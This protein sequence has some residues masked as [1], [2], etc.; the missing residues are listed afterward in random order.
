MSNLLEY[1]KSISSELQSIKNRV[2]NLVTH[3]PEDWRYKEI[4]LS[5]LIRSFLPKKFSVGTWFVVCP[6]DDYWKVKEKST[7]IDI[8]IYND[9][10]PLLFKKW[11][12]IICVPDA[13][14]AIIEVKSKL[15]NSL[16]QTRH[17]NSKSLYN[18]ILKV[19]KNWQIIIQWK[20]HKND[21]LVLKKLF[22]NGI[23]SFD[24]EFNYD[25]INSIWCEQVFQ[26]L[27]APIDLETVSK[28][29]HI[30]FNK[31][32]F[33][34]RFETETLKSHFFELEDLSYAFFISNLMA[35]LSQDTAEYN[36][37]ILFPKNKNNRFICSY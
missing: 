10:S 13:V 1:Y 4:V 18:T 12:F 24:W 33:M 5:E 16:S 8:I 3:R 7:Q 32:I 23:F 14:E 31:D 11:D 34:K 36:K 6:W 27:N 37:F 15:S 19:N 29:N 28:V 22:F 25:Y 26:L 20:T 2:R 9:S 30:T 17:K 21:Y 35:Y